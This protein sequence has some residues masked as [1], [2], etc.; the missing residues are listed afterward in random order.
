LVV[1][2][3]ILTPGE[4]ALV[5]KAEREMRQ[6]KFVT[7]AQL[8]HDLDRSPSRRRG[9]TAS[10]ISRGGW[11]KKASFTRQPAGALPGARRTLCE[12]LPNGPGLA[13]EK[14]RMAPTNRCADFR[15]ASLAFVLQFVGRELQH[16][17]NKLLENGREPRQDLVHDRLRDGFQLSAVA[18]TERTRLVAPDN[19]RRF[20]SRA[21]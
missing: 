19:A 8:R 17:R 12:E 11:Q 15:V 6:G 4:S 18:R 9:K 14:L 20:G 21:R 3:D 7:L 16:D 1:P 13:R 2:D 5:K 10:L